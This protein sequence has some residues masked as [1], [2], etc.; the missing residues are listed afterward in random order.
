METP[1]TLTLRLGNRPVTPVLCGAGGCWALSPHL[2]GEEGPL[3]SSHPPS[4]PPART[5]DPLTGLP[6]LGC[7]WQDAAP[8]WG[9]QFRT[10]ACPTFG[11]SGPICP[12]PDAPG[13]SPPNLSRGGD[14]PPPRR[15]ALLCPPAPSWTLSGHKSWCGEWLLGTQRGMRPFPSP[16]PNSHTGTPPPLSEGA[17]IQL[18]LPCRQPASSTLG[19]ASSAQNPPLG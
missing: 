5:Q 13:C 1:G 18:P 4:P 15:P 17:A 9:V 3:A 7:G 2:L 8:P 12:Y 6:V 14:L 19:P 11:H 10:R 16:N